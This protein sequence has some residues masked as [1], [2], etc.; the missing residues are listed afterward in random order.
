MLAVNHPNYGWLV[1]MGNFLCADEPP[2]HAL[3]IAAPYAVHAHAKD[4]LLKRENPG[5]GWFPTR[6]GWV[7]RGTVVG[8]GVVPIA[9]CVQVLRD[10]GYDGWLSL[11]FEGMEENLT[12]LRCGLA[13]LRKVTAE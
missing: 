11:E 8:H 2:M 7:L 1:D 12:A 10:A 6:N 9:D 13:Y 3:P 4:F 5:E